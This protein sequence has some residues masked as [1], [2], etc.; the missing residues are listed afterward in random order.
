MAVFADIIECMATSDNVVRA[1]LTPMY[2]DIPTLV[3]MLT[4]NAG[5]GERQ[6]LK[7][8]PFGK[9]GKTLLYDPPIDE[10]SIL[11]LD[12]RAGETSLH[13]LIDG[14]SICIVVQGR[15]K[16]AAEDIRRGEVL[17]IPAGSSVEW[18]ADKDGLVLY[19]AFCQVA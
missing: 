15:G 9:D 5:P 13:R 1:G 14:P 12:L 4:Y 17:F 8:T 18:T 6:L 16:A 7:P 3:S 11:K 19:R 2:R 10:F